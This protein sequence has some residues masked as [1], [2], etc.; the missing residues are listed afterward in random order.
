MVK[1]SHGYKSRHC[2]KVF[3]KK[4]R[5]K[6]M[7]PLGRYLQPYEVGNKVDII[8]DPS[9]QKGQPHYKHQ[10]RT[11]TII[12]KRGRA[13]VITMKVGKK[14]FY[15]IARPEHMRFRSET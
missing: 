13:Y 6:G 4:V 7:P 10:G 11:G 14:D 12:E 8:I 2:R 5:Q 9:V 3:K 15:I 1:K